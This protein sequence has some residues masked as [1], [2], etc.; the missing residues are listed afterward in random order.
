MHAEA[1]RR[2]E[3]YLCA[4]RVAHDKVNFIP[5]E[6]FIFF[7]TKTRFAELRSEM[8]D[9]DKSISCRGVILSTQPDL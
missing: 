7:S 9:H 6:I 3:V 1:T 4:K 5:G 2:S 8:R